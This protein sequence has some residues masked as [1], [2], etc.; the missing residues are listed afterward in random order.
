MLAFTDDFSLMHFSFL[1]TV[2]FWH[3]CRRCQWCGNAGTLWWVLR[4]EWSFVRHLTMSAQ[5]LYLFALVHS[6]VQHNICQMSPELPLA[7]GFRANICSTTLA[8]FSFRTSWKIFGCHKCSAFLQEVFTEMEEKYGEVEE[9]NVCDNL[10]DHL[11]GNVYVKVDDS[12]IIINSE[13]LTWQNCIDS[14][15]LWSPCNCFLTLDVV[16][17]WRRRREGSYGPQ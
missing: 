3:F 5:L 7:F 15:I 2:S 17:P 11:V 16:S 13:E 9:M 1:L 14:V 12:F 10:G 6:M 8:F 4:G